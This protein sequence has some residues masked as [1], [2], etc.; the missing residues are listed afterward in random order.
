MLHTHG[1]RFILSCS[2]QVPVLCVWKATLPYCPHSFT[3]KPL[4]PRLSTH[5]AITSLV[6]CLS[7]NRYQASQDAMRAYFSIQL[8]AI[9]SIAFSR[10]CEPSLATQFLANVTLRG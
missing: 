10:M 9:S 1:L 2:L 8:A 4:A 5:K 7:A 6:S 3:A